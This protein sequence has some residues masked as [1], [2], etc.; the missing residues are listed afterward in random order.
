MSAAMRIPL[1]RDLLLDRQHVS[2]GGRAARF[3]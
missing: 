3:P 1:Q 2:F